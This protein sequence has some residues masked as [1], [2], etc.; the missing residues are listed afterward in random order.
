MN[1]ISFTGLFLCF[2]SITTYAAYPCPNGPAPGERQVGVTGGANGVAVVPVCES[3]GSANTADE[4]VV[5][6]SY[7]SEKE[8]QAQI[9]RGTYSAFVRGWLVSK[10]FS[11]RQLSPQA[12]RRS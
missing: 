6:E 3:D 5:F 12:S 4:R 1:R 9:K 11:A 2:L 8:R 10:A 7:N